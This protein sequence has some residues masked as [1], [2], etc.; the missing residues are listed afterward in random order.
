MYLKYPQG[1]RYLIIYSSYIMINNFRNYLCV[2]D[3]L[4]LKSR[5]SKYLIAVI[6]ELCFLKE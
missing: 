6:C 5:T 4:L 1:G 2:T 3:T